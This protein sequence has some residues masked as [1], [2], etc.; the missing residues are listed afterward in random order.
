M[1]RVLEVVGAGGL[2]VEIKILGSEY[3]NK[4]S[5]GNFRSVKGSSPEN[6]IARPLSSINTKASNILKKRASG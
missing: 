1:Y 6:S 3:L 5:Y 2:Y 4:S